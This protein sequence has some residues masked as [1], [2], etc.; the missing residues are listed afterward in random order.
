MTWNAERTRAALFV[1]RWPMKC[2]RKSLP[3]RAAR[4]A[5]STAR[6]SPKSRTPSPARASTSASS[7]YLV[8]ATRVT[9]EGSRRARWQAA[10]MRSRTRARLSRSRSGS[11]AIP[12]LEEVGRLDERPLD[13][14]FLEQLLIAPALPQFELP[15][16]VGLG[17]LER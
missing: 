12:L 17:L 2:H 16:D 7:A 15:A 5:P 13:E 10:A 1:C 9:V 14:V 3:N 6:L 4:A 11:V 8:T